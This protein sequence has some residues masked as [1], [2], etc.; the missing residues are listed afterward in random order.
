MVSAWQNKYQE[1]IAAVRQ[2]LLDEIRKSDEFATVEGSTFNI[3]GE[4]VYVEFRPWSDKGHVN[5]R[6]GGLTLRT[7]DNSLLPAPKLKQIT[8]RLFQEAQGAKETRR[9]QREDELEY[10][11]MGQFLESMGLDSKST[12]NHV[13]L[14][15]G[16]HFY[17]H[18]YSN[19]PVKLEL[20]FGTSDSEKDALAQVMDLMKKLNAQEQS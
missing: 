7:D 2:Q 11:R 17:L 19:G 13:K 18:R 14:P 16:K 4:R 10:Q 20:T 6:V 3:Q 9:R 8:T 1:T 12:Y 15:N 5:V